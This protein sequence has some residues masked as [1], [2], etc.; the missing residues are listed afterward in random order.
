LISLGV[1]TSWLWGGLCLAQ[2]ETYL[3]PC[4]L[5]ADAK[6]NRLYIAADTGAQI[7]VWDT[8]SRQVIQNISVAAHPR[9]V[10]LSQDGRTLYVTS[11]VPAGEVLIVDTNTRRIQH[12]V[13]VGHTPVAMALSPDERTL[14][15]CNQFDNSVSVVDLQ[16]RKCVHRVT[17]LREPVALAITSTGDAVFVV[18]RL[19]LGTAN[20]S[21][22]ACAVSVIDTAAAR[23]THTVELPDGATNAQGIAVSADGHAY[24]V[25]VLARYQFPVTFLE[26]GW[27]NTNALSVLHVPDRRFVNTVLL[28][29]PQRGAADPFAVACTADG[30]RLLVTHAGSHELS[31]IDREAMHRL[32]PASSSPRSFISSVASTGD[33]VVTE[34]LSRADRLPNDLSFLQGIRRRIPLK[35][36]G[37]R[38]L[39]IL[40][41]QVYTGDYYSDSLSQIDLSQSR[42]N[43][44]AILLTRETSLTLR[45]RGEMFFHDA[46]DSYQ[47]WHSCATCHGDQAR[48]NAHNWDLL[49]DGIANP[50]NSKSL[51]LSHA[52]PPMMAT[53]VRPQMEAAIS[54]GIRYIKWIRPRQGQIEAIAAY[55]SHLEPVP[56]PHLSQSR[57]NP[58]ARR[59]ETLF[60]KA[61]CIECHTPPYYTNQQKVDVGTSSYGDNDSRYDVPT[62]VEVWRT[63]P[64]LHDGRAASVV[65]ILTIHNSAERH[66]TVSDLTEKDLQDLEAYVLTR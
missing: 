10:A 8:G 27:V 24:V 30:N 25:H 62:L 32:L 53:G 39:A 57:L 1:L 45:R 17:V 7:L 5:A 47:G 48:A 51:L 15:V 54:S 20:G 4:A 28:D 63:A 56:S 61:G 26:K 46:S 58:S 43:C 66:G 11:A 21:Y 37:P 41:S 13:P 12:R 19:P 64:Y 3:S 49:N 44:R 14:Y 22:L 2:S 9:D 34:Q 42:A 35:G 55:L 38:S 60:K 52:T 59:G 50:K 31:V 36:N 40:G 29:D 6:S 33:I 65:D 16:T 18:N 23:V